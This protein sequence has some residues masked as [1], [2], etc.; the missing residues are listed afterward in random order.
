MRSNRGLPPWKATCE[1]ERK[2]MIEWSIAEIIALDNQHQRD[3]V[4][5]SVWENIPPPSRDE[6]LK[7]AKR[8]ARRGDL[9]PLRRLYPEIAE[10]IHEP[11]R[12][13]GQRRPYVMALQ[14]GENVYSWAHRAQAEGM[15]VD[16]VREL[17]EIVWPQHYGRWKRRRDDGPSA[18]EIAGVF[19]GLTADEVRAAIKAR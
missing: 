14:E 10:Y 13:R 12:V 15:A 4:P 6:R 5:Q 11:K 18:E 7:A 19:C 9:S 16:I 2:W 1:R 17:R 8:R 3:D